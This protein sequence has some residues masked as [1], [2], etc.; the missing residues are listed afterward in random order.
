MMKSSP[1]KICFEIITISDDKY[2]IQTVSE[3][4]AFIIP[5]LKK[6]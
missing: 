1:E 5:S 2:I 4:I 3:K 6:L